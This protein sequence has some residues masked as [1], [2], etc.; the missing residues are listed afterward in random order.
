MKKTDV[1]V[2]GGAGYIG[3][4]TLVELH[5]SGYRPI[6]VDNLSNTSL[7]NIKGAEKIIKN[8]ITFYEFDCTDE[9]QMNELFELENNI[10]AVI[11]FAAFK[12]V[13]ESVR[14][15]KKYYDNNI[16]SL[17]VL[18]KTMKRYKVNNIIFS[19]SCTVYGSPDVLPVSELAPFKR[20]ESPYGET[21]QLCEKLIDKSDIN[22][23]S[24]RYFNPV[25]S[26]ESCLI[27]DCSADKPNNLV[28]I[29]CEVAS[30]KRDSMQIF[31]NDYNTID[32]TCVRDYIHVV[33][34]AKAHV[35]A[36]NHILNKKEIKTAYNIGVGKGVSVQ[37]VVASFEK[38]NDIKISYKIGPRRAGDV[39]EIYSNNTKINTELNWFPVMSFESALK[40]AWTWER[41]K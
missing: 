37:E 1:L 18:L 15:P 13:E 28:P 23:I 4:H 16:G 7:E 9:N 38:I 31:G 24:L 10:L 2:T 29:I 14:E 35:A 3:S 39:E 36:L 5:N 30:G 21:K 11:H 22:S 34:L 19:S 8:K 27:G 6:I 12:A 17:E 40:T 32:G 41:N 20:A 33:D 26:H 25:G